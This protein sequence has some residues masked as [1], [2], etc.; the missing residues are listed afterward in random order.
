MLGEVG[1]AAKTL[2]CSRVALFTG[3]AHNVNLT[4]SKK[5]PLRVCVDPLVVTFDIFD[6]VKKS[7]EAEGVDV[8][9][10]DQ[11]THTR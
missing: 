8:V 11:V 10:Y 2:G 6:R 1:D 9:V 3:T 5:T 4:I 7:L